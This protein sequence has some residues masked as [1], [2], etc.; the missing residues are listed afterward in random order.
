M[1]HGDGNLDRAIDLLESHERESFRN[2]VETEIAFNPYNIFICRSKKIL[3]DYYS[4]IFPWLEKCEEIFGFE[5]KDSYG[6]KRIYGFLAER[7]LSF[8]FRKYA[9]P[10]TW[11]I[12]F[13]DIG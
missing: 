12:Y 6:K 8:W 5:M 2:F 10:I 9:K 11:P 7:Y 4:S 13:K 1:Y 3:F